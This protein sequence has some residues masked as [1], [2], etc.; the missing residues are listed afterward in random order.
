[1]TGRN[2]KSE[3]LNPVGPEYDRPPINEHEMPAGGAALPEVSDKAKYWIYVWR[4]D[5]Q[6]YVWMEAVICTG[7]VN[8]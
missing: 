5:L 6:A 3:Q 7:Y 2:D 8:P 4:A 1:M